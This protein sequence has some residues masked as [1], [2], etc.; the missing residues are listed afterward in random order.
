[1]GH[2][3]RAALVL[4]LLL[5]W[6][7]VAAA[8]GGTTVLSGSNA[9][10]DLSAQASDIVTAEGQKAVDLTAYP[11]RRGNGA[12]DLEA[13]VRFSID[14]GPAIRARRNGDGVEAIVPVSSRGQWRSWT[15]VTTVRGAGGKLSVTGVPVAR[16]EDSLPPALVP[17]G[18]V[19]ALLGI[20][21]ALLVQ[22]RRRAQEAA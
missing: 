3:R 19:L 22:R 14:D 16:Q 21:Y 7:A 2:V 10:Y 6:P 18:V 1:M 4:L 13:D 12:P 11:I 9:A 8:H 15:I 17:V 20:G 5:I